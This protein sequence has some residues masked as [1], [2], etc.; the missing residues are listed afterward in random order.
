MQQPQADPAPTPPRLRVFADRSHYRSEWRRWLSPILKPLWNDRSQAE[1]IEVYGSRA[2]CFEDAATVDDADFVALTMTWNHYLD[3]G[4]TA[5][6]RTLAETAVSAG[7]RILVYAMGDFDAPVDLPGVIKL[8]PSLRRSRRGPH[9][10][11]LPSIHGDLV[12]VYRD[13][14]PSLRPWRPKPTVGFCGQAGGLTPR[15]AA[16]WIRN[17]GRYGR[18]RWLRSGYEP[19]F[20][21]PSSILRGRV[22]DRLESSDRVETRFLLRSAY[23]AGISSF[24]DRSDPQHPAR[25]EFI[26]NLDAS[27]YAVCIRGTGNFSRRFYEALCW[28]RIPV[29]VDTDCV[30]P[31]DGEVDWRRYCVWIDPGDRPN[32]A[33]RVAEHHHRLGPEGFVEAQ[34]DCRRLWRERLSEDGFYEHLHGLLT[35]V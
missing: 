3:R 5:E 29:F 15:M 1:R 13:G 21:V 31:Y 7:K 22:L 24:Q 9:D 16:S 6:A 28:G 4:R 27:D 20:L 18:A 33:E 26:E 17:L 25:L 2:R 30:L 34:R 14:K 12:E 8:G 19:P 10:H 35:V 32:I 23:W 11:A